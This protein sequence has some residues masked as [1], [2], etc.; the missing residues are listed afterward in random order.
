MSVIIRIATLEDSDILYEWR[1]DELVRKNSFSQGVIEYDKH[2]EWLR[3]FL[4]DKSCRI[5]IM[6]DKEVM[7]GQVKVRVIDNEAEIGYSIGKEYRGHGYGT[8]CLELVKS[9]IKKEF[10]NVQK[11][12]GRVKVDNVISER[13]FEKA[14]Y[15]AQYVEYVSNV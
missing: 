5:Y 3:K 13:A 12:Y 1:N 4:T 15:H 11:V 14:G 7:V 2:I 10:P 6:V 8:K 9:E